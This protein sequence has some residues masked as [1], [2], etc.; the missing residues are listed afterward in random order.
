MNCR[1]SL[2]CDRSLTLRL[3]LK[4]ISFLYKA[5]LTAS[6]T[7]LSESRTMATSVG[8]MSFTRSTMLSAICLSLPI[9]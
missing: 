6:A 9:A 1:K 7:G 8:S 2:T 4:G 5:A 3:F